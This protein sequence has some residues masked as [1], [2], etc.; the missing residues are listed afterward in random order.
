[1]LLEKWCNSYLLWKP[2]LL[3]RQKCAARKLE[4]RQGLS[5]FLLVHPK[6]ALPTSWI[7]VEASFRLPPMLP[8]NTHQT[9]T[10]PSYA[11]LQK[12]QFFFSFFF[13][14]NITWLSV[15]YPASLEKDTPFM[16]NECWTWKVWLSQ[17]STCHVLGSC[18]FLRKTFPMTNLGEILVWRN[19]AIQQSAAGSFQQFCERVVRFKIKVTKPRFVFAKT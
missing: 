1:M 13:F 14:F 2:W 6:A 19:I 12:A 11:L 3:P 9:T 18:G 5:P 10:L 15:L 17:T 7:F 8:I 16:V 4:R